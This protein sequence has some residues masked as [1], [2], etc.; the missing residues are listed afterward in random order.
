[1]SLKDTLNGELKDAMRSGAEVR[2][3]T[4]RQ[5]L[6]AIRHAELEQRTAAVKKIGG[7]P[8][9]AQIKELESLALT[10]TDIV[11]VIQKEAKARREAIADAEKA[12]RPD[13]VAVMLKPAA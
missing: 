6:A 5:V 7:E 12:S 4:L 10:D 2:K 1:M 8:T 3:T 13:L 9:D 11:A